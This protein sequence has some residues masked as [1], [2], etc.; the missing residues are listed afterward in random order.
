VK[1]VDFAGAPY[2]AP[3]ED[4]EEEI[5][6]AFQTVL[7][8]NWVE[9][10]ETVFED[11]DRQSVIEAAREV[12]TGD[13]LAECERLT[14]K[15]EDGFAGIFLYDEIGPQNPVRCENHDKCT[16]GRVKKG[17]TGVIILNVDSNTCT[18]TGGVAGEDSFGSTCLVR[19]FDDQSPNAL[20]TATVERNGQGDWIV[21]E[22][23]VTTSK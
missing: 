23:E 9:D 10:S 21:T 11:F 16:L 7:R 13:A 4:I 14:K 6:A 1:D 8:C 18:D 2:L 19:D 3:P 17:S 20:R 22:W 15:G 12:A 5:R